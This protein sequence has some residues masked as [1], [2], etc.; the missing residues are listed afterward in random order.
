[1]INLTPRSVL[2]SQVPDDVSDLRLEFFRDRRSFYKAY[3]G[4][5][6]Y[7]QSLTF[8]I[9]APVGVAAIVLGVI[10]GFLPKALLL[11]LTFVVITIRNQWALR[12]YYRIMGKRGIF[13]TVEST[14]IYYVMKVPDG[15]YN[16]PILGDSWENVKRV[17]IHRGHAV[18]YLKRK[19]NLSMYFMRTDDPAGLERTVRA[20]WKMA[21][22]PEAREGF[23]HEYSETDRDELLNFV[24][25]RF[26]ESFY[27]WRENEPEDVRTDLALIPASPDRPYHTLCTVGCGTRRMAVPFK[28]QQEQG[29]P[30]RIE[31]LMY[32][33][34]TWEFEGDSLTSEDHYWT[35]HVLEK[36]AGFCEDPSDWFCWGHAITANDDAMPGDFAGV[37]FL[38][39]LP[40]VDEYSRVT[41]PSGKSVAFIQLLPLTRKELD[42][43]KEFDGTPEFLAWLNPSGEDWVSFIS[44]RFQR[45]EFL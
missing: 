34:S 1:M 35:I 44:D 11:A 39:P 29:V 19:S 8:F 25:G 40:A 23:V 31:L 21:L 30:D 24:E 43:R 5:L 9:L 41:L 12:D 33:P 14:G 2:D 15:D 42:K 18:F 17:R 28:L 38:C 4:D 7:Y 26:G 45:A 16:V 22:S 13:P 10:F 36:V 27:Y 32:I 20:Y 3:W 6:Y 37:L